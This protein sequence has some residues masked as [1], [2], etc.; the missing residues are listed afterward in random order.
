MCAQT[1]ICI[2]IYINTYVYVLRNKPT[3]HVCLYPQ[4]HSEAHCHVYT[5]LYIYTCTPCIPNIFV[6][7]I[8][9]TQTSS[10]SLFE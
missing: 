10:V 3:M 6:A 4:K 5:D 2:L 7:M 9:I 1:Y 8:D